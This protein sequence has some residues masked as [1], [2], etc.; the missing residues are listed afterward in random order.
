MPLMPPIAMDRFL[1]SEESSVPPALARVRQDL[2]RGVPFEWTLGGDLSLALVVPTGFAVLWRDAD[3]AVV[4]SEG[5]DGLVPHA[6]P[7][8]A[9]ALEQAPARLVVR[10]A[11][12]IRAVVPL[13]TGLQRITPDGDGAATLAE[14]AVVAWRLHAGTVRGPGEYG[15]FVELAWRAVGKGAP[16]I[17]DT[18][19]IGMRRGGYLP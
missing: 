5:E 10:K 9:D 11:R 17:V 13:A 12:T 1:V 6:A 16:A 7:R 3:P 4:V 18:L 14:L 19:R 2:V 8:G 15:S